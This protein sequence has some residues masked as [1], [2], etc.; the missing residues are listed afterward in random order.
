M[1]AGKVVFLEERQKL[2]KPWDFLNLL[3]LKPKNVL[4]M[5]LNF[6]PRSLMSIIYFVLIEKKCVTKKNLARTSHQQ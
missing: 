5:F 6:W 4:N 2:L 3:G 1:V